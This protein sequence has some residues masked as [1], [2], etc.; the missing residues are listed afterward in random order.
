MLTWVI[1]RLFWGCFK[2]S[3]MC[4]PSSV[5]ETTSAL[6]TWAIASTIR[7]NVP[8]NNLVIRTFG[9]HRFVATHYSLFK[10]KY[11]LISI[12][13]I[14]GFIIIDL[15]LPRSKSKKKK[16][17]ATRGRCAVGEMAGHIFC[18][19]GL[20]VLKSGID[21]ELN[22]F[23]IQSGLRSRTPE[24]AISSSVLGSTEIPNLMKMSQHYKGMRRVKIS[25][26]CH[27]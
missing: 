10:I 5:A 27:V 13:R 21:F 1:G 19:G 3:L 15:H 7:R 26:R 11:H 14:C 9:I 23:A 25:S 16:D 18:N 8:R 4:E 6:F 22:A 12:I 24:P 17:Y 2:L 20:I